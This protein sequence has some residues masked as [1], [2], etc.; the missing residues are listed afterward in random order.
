MRKIILEKYHIFLKIINI[1]NILSVSSLVIE[2]NNISSNIKL[3]EFLSFFIF[4]P[5]FQKIVIFFKMTFSVVEQKIFICGKY[6][7]IMD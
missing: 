7:K 5:I 6:I 3:S 1:L 2:I 4:L